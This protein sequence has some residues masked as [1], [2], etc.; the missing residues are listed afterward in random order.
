MWEEKHIIS[1][2]L[3]LCILVSI[4]IPERPLWQTNSGPYQQ[5]QHYIVAP[6]YHV[7]SSK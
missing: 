4:S 5:H 2:K 6:K 7:T 3:L 1:P